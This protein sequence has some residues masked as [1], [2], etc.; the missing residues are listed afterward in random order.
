MRPNWR[1]ASLGIFELW[2]ST[3]EIGHTLGM[4]HCMKQVVGVQPNGQVVWS[5]MGTRE[6]N[7]CG[8]VVSD[9]E[10]LSAQLGPNEAGQVHHALMFLFDDDGKSETPDWHVLHRASFGNH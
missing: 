7:S 6:A 4:D 8:G 3:H 10:E 2:R 1:R 5:V 9:T